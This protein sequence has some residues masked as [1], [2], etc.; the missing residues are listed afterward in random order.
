M[1]TFKKFAAPLALAAASLV[2]AMPAQ[3][4][5]N[6]HDNHQQAWQQ[7]PARNTQIRQDINS[8]GNA[9]DRAA[10]RRTISKREAQSLRSQARDV[11]RLYQSYARNGLTR[12]EVAALENRV[13]KVRGALRMD[14]RDWNNRRG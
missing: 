11:Q 14:R 9:I 1:M 12:N 13:N 3:A 6:R 4:R 2:V 5:D 10:A 8:L 7:S